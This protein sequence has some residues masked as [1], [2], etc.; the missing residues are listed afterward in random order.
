[1]ISRELNHNLTALA[2]AINVSRAQRRIPNKQL[3]AFYES[4]WYLRHLSVHRGTTAVL[5]VLKNL[6]NEARLSAMEGR[7]PIW[8]KHFHYLSKELA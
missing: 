3:L 4:V 6:S 8:P 2:T 7:K 1:L 5:K